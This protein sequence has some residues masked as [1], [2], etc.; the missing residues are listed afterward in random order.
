[1]SDQAL[2]S[3]R[4]VFLKAMLSLF[5]LIFLL[6][7]LGWLEEAAVSIEMKNS[8]QSPSF[9]HWLGTDFLGRDIFSRG[10]HGIKLA[11]FVGGGSAFLSVLLGLLGGLI[12]ARFQRILGTCLNW[13]ANTLESI[14]YLLIVAL[15]SW[16]IGPGIGNLVIALGLTSWVLT[17]RVIRS[18]ALRQQ[19]LD[20]FHATKALGLPAWRQVLSHL[21]P[22]VVELARH[23]FPVQMMAAIKYEV[24]LSFVGLGV[25]AGTPSWGVM[26]YDAKDELLRGH[27]YGLVWASF[28]MFSFV[29]SLSLCRFP[30]QARASS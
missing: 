9:S 12:A 4:D 21:L 20:Y 13:L 8:F 19:S 17:F 27:W 6:T 25:E 28:L 5:T 14:P 7:N 1:M 22:N 2:S 26:I 23:Q 30:S 3:W 11:V 24:I 10:L 18:E 15:L 29:L 16:S